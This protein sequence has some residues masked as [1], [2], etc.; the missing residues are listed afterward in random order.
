MV[1]IWISLQTTPSILGNPGEIQVSARLFDLNGQPVSDEFT[2]NP[3]PAI[4]ST[5]AVSAM[6][7]GRFTVAWSQFDFQ[8]AGNSWD[9]Y[10]RIFGPNG[11]AQGDSFRLNQYVLYRQFAPRIATLG[12]SQLVVW[13]S[14][15][16]D[17]SLEGVYGRA[18]MDGNIAGDEFRINVQTR[19][20]QIDPVVASDG[21]DR[22]LALW[23]SFSAS[24][25]FD[26]IGRRYAAPNQAFAITRASGSA[27]AGVGA[28]SLPA[29]L[30]ATR[31][32]GGKLE[33]AWKSA[34][35]VSYQVQMSTNLQ[36]WSNVG[37]ARS[38]SGATDSVSIDTTLPAA[39]YRV[40]LVP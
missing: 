18:L 5:P 4:C 11:A 39:F 25:S 34:P 35:G 32:G 17:G 1:F 14:A 33:V 3:G 30:R 27:V 8:N 23:S 24:G 26:V 19:S 21:T 10:A 13:T 6:A 29:T 20:R 36:A 15:V 31:S 28:G 9:I 2:V 7:D 37:E 22:F 12:N 40:I 16:Q 38:A